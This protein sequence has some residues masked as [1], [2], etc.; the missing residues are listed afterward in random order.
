MHS[1]NGL[2][3]ARSCQASHNTYNDCQNHQF[4]QRDSSVTAKEFTHIFHLFSKESSNPGSSEV[5]DNAN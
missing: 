1:L 3:E 5:A 2:Q 4:D